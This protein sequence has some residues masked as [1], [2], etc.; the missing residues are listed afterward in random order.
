MEQKDTM[1][2]QLRSR[3]PGALRGSA[4]LEIQTRETQKLIRGRRP[5]GG[6]PGWVGLL[7][8]AALTKVI[9]TGVQGDDPWADWWLWRVEESLGQSRDEIA[10]MTREIRTRLKGVRA[11][12]IDLAQSMAPAEIELNFSTPYG[13]MAAYLLADH[14]ELVRGVLTARHVGLLNRDTADRLLYSASRAVRRALQAALGYKYLGVTRADAR[15]GTAKAARARDLMGAVPQE[16]VDGEMRA[17][18]AP[19]LRQPEEARDDRGPPSKA[20]TEVGGADVEAGAI[21]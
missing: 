13:F 6:K 4:V 7:R 20:A 16:V 5:E 2:L 3:A 17:E 15:Q 11:L 8:F 14:D 18:H 9:W 19:P 1:S 10:R 12:R 21:C